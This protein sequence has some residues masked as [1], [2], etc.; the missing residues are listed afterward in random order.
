MLIWVPHSLAATSNYLLSADIEG[1]APSGWQ[2]GAGRNY[3]YTPAIDGTS[4]LGITGTFVGCAS[5][6]FT[7]TNDV[8]VFFLA[9]PGAGSNSPILALQNGT[10]ATVATVQ[11]RADRI[12]IEHGTASAFSMGAALTSTS[13]V[14]VHYVAGSGSNGRL[15]LYINKNS[16][17]LTRPSVSAS[18]TTGTSTTGIGNI[19][20]YAQGAGNW[21][22]DKFRVSASEIGSNP[23]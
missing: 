4:S 6:A 23:T 19:V 3:A 8:W 7:V 22:Y 14:W 20:V 15:D 16:T 9:F 11:F 18:I 1:S 2:T 12:N 10:P 13:A 21:V 5:P 17:S